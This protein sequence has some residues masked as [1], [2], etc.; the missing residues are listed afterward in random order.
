[1]TQ[2]VTYKELLQW[3]VAELGIENRMEAELLLCH[4]LD[5]NRALLLAH[6]TDEADAS[7]IDAYRNLVMKRKAGEP[8]QYL[9]GTANFMGLDLLVTPDVLIPRFDTE[10][11][12]EQALEVLPKK[13]RPV[14]LDICT[15]SGAIALAINH[16]RKDAVVYAGDLSEQALQV[17]EENNRRCGTAVTFRQGDLTA[18]FA[19]LQGMVDVLVSNPP[20][21]TTEEMQELPVDVQQEP[22]LAL[23]GGEDGLAFYRRLVAE[24]PMLLVN[25]GWLL[26]EIGWK[27][28]EAVAQ[29]MLQQG[30]CDVAVIQ[31]W[32]GNDRVVIGRCRKD[33]AEV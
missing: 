32:Q 24:A 31:D 7:R 14:V 28:G 12:V 4:V 18:P 2:S 20:Y 9:L 8:F 10:R 25:D 33:A 22:H 5:L 23:W 6:D 11:L 16:Y 30:F 3:A 1:M 13:A 29:L 21:I 15:G 26:F 17:A 19:D 27:Q